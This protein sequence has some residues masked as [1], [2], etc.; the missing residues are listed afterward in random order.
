MADFIITRRFDEFIGN[1]TNV[2]L[3]VK[4]AGQLIGN[5]DDADDIVQDA[6]MKLHKYWCSIYDHPNPSAYIYSVLKSATDD[7]REKTRYSQL[8]TSDED[9]LGAI[10]ADFDVESFVLVREAIQEILGRTRSPYERQLLRYMSMGYKA[11]EIASELNRSLPTI[12]S[13]IQRL[14][15]RLRNDK[16]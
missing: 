5:R 2:G 7:F 14:R 4:H 9:I 16:L 11:R 8:A 6:Q 15:A 1:E 13:H 3:M 10:P 12:E